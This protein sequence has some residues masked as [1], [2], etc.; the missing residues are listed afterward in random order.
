[1]AN[2][3][4]FLVT[5]VLVG[6]GTVENELPNNEGAEFGVSESEIINGTVTSGFPSVGLTNGC[7][8]TLIGRRTVITAAHCVASNGQ[9]G[10]FCSNGYCVSG[11]YYKHP[12]YTTNGYFNDIAVLR[13]DS[14]FTAISGIAPTRIASAATAPSVSMSIAIVGFGC[15]NWYTRAGIGT[16]RYGT[17]A[18]HD[19]DPLKIQWD[20]RYGSA[21]TCP[22]DSGGAV[23]S[24]DYYGNITDCQIG[25]I[26][27]LQGESDGSDDVATRVDPL[28]GWVRSIAAD[29][30]VLSCDQTLCGDGTCH[31]GEREKNCPSDCPPVC[32][33]FLCESGEEGVCTDDCPPCGDGICTIFEQNGSCYAD[34]GTCGNL[35]CEPSDYDHSII[36]T[37]CW[38]PF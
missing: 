10:T 16:K 33:N 15:T 2:L 38:G 30:T 20:S 8:S 28:A 36:C 22:G 12:S 29:A 37:D 18:L 32:G 14:D 3:K 31:L 23:F 13:L 19:V 17:N 7:S 6:C 21:R 26:S 25:V 34:C 1:M 5:L 4:V 27:H 11:T 9:R 35:I 24:I